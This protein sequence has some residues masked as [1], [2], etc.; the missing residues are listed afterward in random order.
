MFVYINV[1][2]MVL[3]Y[4]VKAS[5]L[6]ACVCVREMREIERGERD[7]THMKLKVMHD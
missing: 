2:D 3:L 4:R 1:N 5:D 7:C 6:C